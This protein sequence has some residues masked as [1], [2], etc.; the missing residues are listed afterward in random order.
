MDGHLV[1]ASSNSKIRCS[2]ENFTLDAER[3][4]AALYWCVR[5]SYGDDAAMLRQTAGC[6]ALKNNSRDQAAFQN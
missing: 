5:T 2:L 6:E 4:L 1:L 3:W